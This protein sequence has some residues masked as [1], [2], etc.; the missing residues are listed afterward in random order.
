MFINKKKTNSLLALVSSRSSLTKVQSFI[1][2]H[3][4]LYIPK[5]RLEQFFQNKE[6]SFFQRNMFSENEINLLREL[7]I[8]KRTSKANLKKGYLAQIVTFILISDSI[9]YSTLE[10]Y[11]QGHLDDF[12]FVI[13]GYLGGF[14]ISESMQGINILIN[15]R[16][17]HYELSNEE[18]NIIFNEIRREWEDLIELEVISPKSI[19]ELEELKSFMFSKAF[20]PL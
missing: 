3:Y 8:E 2:F 7:S 9:N 5:E 12:P 4:N 14:D 15:G 19:A 1:H 16:K 11:I 13:Q 20:K 17:A 10:T 6:I 18:K